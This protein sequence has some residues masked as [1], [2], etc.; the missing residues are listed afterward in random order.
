MKKFM[1]MALCLCAATGA[2]AQEQVLKDADRALKQEA[3]DYASVSKSLRTIMGDPNAANDVR[4]WYLAGKAGTGQYSTGY[5]ALTLGQ[6]VDRKAMSRALVDGFRFYLR[7]LPLDTVIETK[8]DKVKVKTKYSKDIVKSIAEH[9]NDYY[10]AGAI[11]YEEKDFSG[12]YEAWDVYTSIP[13]MTQL[14]K[15]KPEVP[16]DSIMAENL[17]NMGMFA[18]SAEMYPEATDAFL[19]ATE[20]NYPGCD[21]FN[22]A[23]ACAGMAGD[24]DRKFEIAKL[25]YAHRGSENPGYIGEI[26]NGY[27]DRKQNDQAIEWLDKAIADTPENA[28]LYNAKGIL[29]ESSIPEDADAAT[30]EA[31]NEKALV[32][33]KKAVELEPEGAMWNFHYGRMLANKGYRLSDASADLPTA[34]YNKMREEQILPL[35]KDAAVYLEKAIAVDPDAT[36]NALPILRNIYYNLGDAD[37]MKRI[38]DLQ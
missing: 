25:A 3:P 31:G 13:F 2:F 22:N 11:L 19:R 14:G 12:A 33:Y 15:L 23:I 30:V 34:E 21:A 7:A 10:T 37:N 32:F 4:T 1:I 9:Y 28:Q 20:F 36:R 38:E 24:Q 29:I 27:I 26:I 18:Y 35:F 5:Q 6:P 17:Y 16:A 8:G